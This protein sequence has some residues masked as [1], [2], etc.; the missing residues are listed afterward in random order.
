MAYHSVAFDRRGDV[1]TKPSVRPDAPAK[2][3]VLRRIL[4]AVMQSRQRQADRE[5]ARFFQDHG[6]RLTDEI[7]REIERR[8]L[9]HPSTKF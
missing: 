3:G 9:S 8:F 5:I 2:R 7:E 1:F 6:G 4:A